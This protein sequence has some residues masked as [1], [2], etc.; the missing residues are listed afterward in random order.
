MNTTINEI[1]IIDTD[2]HVV[3][4]PDL[5]TSRIASKWG[6][7]VPTCEWDAAPQ[8]DAWY[9][10]TERVGAVGRAGNGR[11]ARVPAVPPA[12]VLRHRSGDVG[13]H[14]AGQVDGQLRHLGADAVPE[15]GRASA[16]RAS[17]RWAIP[18]CMLACIQAYNDFLVDFG[19]RAQALHPVAALPFWDLR[20]TLTEIERCA[21]TAT[22][23][24]C[25]AGPGRTS[26]CRS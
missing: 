13:R 25:Y 18:S 8:E 1:P 3:E 20:P 22:R 10:G 19:S 17:S 11:L 15:R 4:P 9:I 24:S 23:G 5:W 7:N 26:A 12:P 16:P 14:Q 21:P 6:D 2:T